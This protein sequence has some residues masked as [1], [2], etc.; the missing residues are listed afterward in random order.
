MRS[1]SRWSEP[2]GERLGKARAA[3]PLCHPGDIS[4]GPDQHGRRGSHGAKD[5]ELPQ[6]L[7]CGLDQL[8]PI[9]PGRDVDGAGLAELEQYRPG[10]FALG[11]S[12]DAEARLTAGTRVMK[13]G[14]EPDLG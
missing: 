3:F 11:L 1:R 7:K 12:Y 4:V 9:G 14:D 13:A 8:N 6:A 5:R 10:D 2:G